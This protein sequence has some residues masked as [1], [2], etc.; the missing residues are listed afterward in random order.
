MSPISPVQVAKKKGEYIPKE[1]F[2]AFDALIVENYVAGR[3]VVIQDE[4]VERVKKKVGN[5]NNK[6]L[7]VEAAYEAVG[8]KVE[9]D[10]PAYNESYPAKFIFTINDGRDGVPA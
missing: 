10:K 5:C 9:Y 2:E 1:V 6:W 4:V 7:N 3:A 8:W